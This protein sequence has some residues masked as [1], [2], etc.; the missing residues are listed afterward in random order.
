MSHLA[1]SG[2]SRIRELWTEKVIKLNHHALCCHRK[3]WTNEHQIYGSQILRNSSN[4][5]HQN[6]RNKGHL[7]LFSANKE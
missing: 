2:K 7:M 4:V 1:Y 6:K 5:K 3:T